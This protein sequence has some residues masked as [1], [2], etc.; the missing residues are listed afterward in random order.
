MNSFFFLSSVICKNI[1]HYPIWIALKVDLLQ[2]YL[3]RMIEDLISFEYQKA[4]LE[5]SLNIILCLMI[6]KCR[7]WL[8]MHGLIK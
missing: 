6:L 5:Q 8:G 2:N 4:E 1:C 3:K 7:S